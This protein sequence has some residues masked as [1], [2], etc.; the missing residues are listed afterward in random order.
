MKVSD[1][2]A[3]THTAVVTA[4]TLFLVEIAIYKLSIISVNKHF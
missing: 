4:I 2:H 3:R 1:T